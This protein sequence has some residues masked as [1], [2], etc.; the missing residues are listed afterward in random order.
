MASGILGTVNEALGPDILQK[1]SSHVGESQP[2]TQAALGAAVPALL[3]GIMGQATNGGTSGGT[4]GGTGLTS[5]IG[6]LTSG[7]IDPNLIG[8]LGSMLHGSAASGL[9]D[10]GRSVVTSALGNHASQVENAIAAH[11]GVQPAAAAS[12]LGIAGPVV[13]AAIGKQMSGTPTV[14]GLTGLLTSQKSEI[15]GALPA[16]LS[17][18]LGGASLGSVRAA[19]ASAE[20]EASGLGMGK[21]IGLLLLAALVIGGLFWYI[22]NG[23]KPP[24][25]VNSAV[26]TA[27]NAATAVTDGSKAALSA[28]GD[29]FSRKLPNGVE[30]NVPKL[31]VENRLLDYL[32]DAS[33]KPDETT[34]FDFDRLLFDTGASTLQPS[35][36]EQLGNIAAILKAYPKVKVRIGGYTDNTGDKA[37]NL[38]LSTDRA[39]SVMAELVKLGVEPSRMDA[40]GYGEDHPVADNATEEGRSKNR[41]ISIR[42]LEK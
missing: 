25:V 18:I 26:N 5:L 10:T 38:K 32:E 14:S 4:G 29:F 2:N 20:K 6:L 17:G 27:T 33:K 13:M 35:S 28:L 7:R 39:N 24:D 16:G 8:N 11:S 22:N 15:M 21:I 31:G 42:V 3:A 30:L 40:K 12:I 23:A 41:R 19:A 1:I 37:A 34:W 9:M 36:Q